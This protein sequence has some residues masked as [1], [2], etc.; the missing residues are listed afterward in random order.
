ME[1]AR[2]FPGSSFA[3]LPER[4][5][6]RPSA[7]FI[8]VSPRT[9]SRGGILRG[10]RAFVDGDPPRS[11]M[12]RLRSVHFPPPPDTSARG[13]RDHYEALTSTAALAIAK[14]RRSS[15]NFRGPSGGQVS[16]GPSSSRKDFPGGVV[17]CSPC[18]GEGTF[19]TLLKSIEAARADPG[20][21]REFVRARAAGIETRKT[22]T[23]NSVAF[24]SQAATSLAAREARHQGG[25]SSD[26]DALGEGAGALRPQ[27]TRVR[28][29]RGLEALRPVARRASSCG[30][31]VRDREGVRGGR[32]G[33]HPEHCTKNRVKKR[34]GPW[35]D[36]GFSTEVSPTELSSSTRPNL[37][38]IGTHDRGE[39]P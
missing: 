8:D 2:E 4:S 27:I 12:S 36:S 13:K 6:R 3:P 18:L 22:R 7:R 31:A 24:G 10:P 39:S 35:V 16:S 25:G 5:S 33:A 32:H 29:A 21:A 19:L 38:V 26:R 11:F 1:R 9:S 28:P 23:S 20:T 14:G 30:R 37:I 17:P 34:L 15:V